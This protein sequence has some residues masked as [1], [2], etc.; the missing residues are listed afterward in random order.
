MFN[1]TVV[2]RIYKEISGLKKIENQISNL[3]NKDEETF[4]WEYADSKQAYEK[5]L[6]TFTY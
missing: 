4:H 6:D 1:T 3:E 2:F 5:I